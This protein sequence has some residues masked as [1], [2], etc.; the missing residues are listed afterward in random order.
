M[1]KHEVQARFYRLLT[2]YANDWYS[3]A[4]R[5]ESQDPDWS[6]KAEDMAYKTWDLA[7]EIDH[8]S[9]SQF[10]R[11][12]KTWQADYNYIMARFVEWY[13]EVYRG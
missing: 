7:E 11:F 6:A 5:C 8:M 4:I 1:S 3:Q 10:K 2:H 13:P 9:R 12:V